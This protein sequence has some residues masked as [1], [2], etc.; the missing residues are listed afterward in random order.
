[1]ELSSQRPT[2]RRVASNCSQCG[3]QDPKP[4]RCFGHSA[5]SR[6]SSNLQSPTCA[7]MFSPPYRRCGGRTVPIGFRC[8]FA[9]EP[10][11]HG[12]ISLPLVR[13]RSR[14]TAAS[15]HLG[16]HQEYSLSLQSTMRHTSKWRLP[17]FRPFATS[18]HRLPRER[19]HLSM[20]L[21][22][23]CS[24]GWRCCHE[25]RGTGCLKPRAPRLSVRQRGRGAAFAL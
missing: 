5:P 20:S 19:T 8:P 9:R 7:T 10:L 24:V 1:M 21:A 13:V 6:E 15:F 2:R 25:R 3:L 11:C 22:M 17:P 14:Q 4:V 12:Q 16:W 18:T 23:P